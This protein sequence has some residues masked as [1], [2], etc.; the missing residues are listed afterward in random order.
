V[1]A[2]ASRADADID[3]VERAIWVLFHWKLGKVHTHKT[4][5]GDPFSLQGIATPLYLTRCQPNSEQPIAAAL[6]LVDEGL[7]F[8]DGALPHDE[9]K[10]QAGTITERR[11][12]IV[13]PAFLMHIWRPHDYPILDRYVFQA[14]LAL[15]KEQVR[16]NTQPRSWAHY[17][18][19]TRFFDCLVSET[20]LSRRVVD[21]GL[22]VYG[23]TL[24][25]CRE[26][27]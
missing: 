18:E 7:L 13:L 14:M 1:L 15:L 2:G 4:P 23:H 9:F 22:W 10:V 21:K 16:R 26:N 24:R 5:G 12:S 27:D 3:R 8:R 19:Y 20:G 17:E 11:A 25:T 6:N